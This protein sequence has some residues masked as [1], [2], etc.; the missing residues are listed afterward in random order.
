MPLRVSGKNMDIGE[1]LRTHVLDKVQA[2]IAR[3]FDGKITGHVVISPEGSAFRTDCSLHLSSGMNLQSEGRAHEPY[4][5]FDQAADKIER[6]LR[7]YKQRLKEHASGF[8]GAA[9]DRQRL[10]VANFVIEAPAEDTEEA[11]A[12]FSP[13]VVAEGAQPLKVLSVASA[14]SELDLTGSPVVVFQHATSSRVNI[15]YR[16]RDGAIGWLDP[17]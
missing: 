9:S 2:L 8:D 16:R 12:D 13:V 1:S 14:V 5:S 3:Y 4:A 7:R 15:V 10:E 6:R 11:P 17:R